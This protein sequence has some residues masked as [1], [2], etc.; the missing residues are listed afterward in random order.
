M[1]ASLAQLLFL[2]K[3]VNTGASNF[4]VAF[5]CLIFL[6]AGLGLII[7]KLNFSSAKLD[8]PRYYALV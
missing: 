8:D 7:F 3:G 4:V 5:L 6:L 1:T 2:A